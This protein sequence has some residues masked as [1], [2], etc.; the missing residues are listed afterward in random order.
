M[1]ATAASPRNRPQRIVLK[2]NRCAMVS[3]V[4]RPPR[5]VGIEQ[6]TIHENA[7]ARSADRFADGV[8]DV[9][10]L[11][12]HAVALPFGAAASITFRRVRNF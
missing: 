6:A 10:S 2:G 12:P 11:W 8:P 7:A 1:P 4:R 3:N 9:R 5:A